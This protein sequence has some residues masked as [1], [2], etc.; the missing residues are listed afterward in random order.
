MGE[1]CPYCRQGKRAKKTYV[2]NVDVDGMVHK[3]EFGNSVL[4]QLIA[5]EPNP[6]MRQGAIIEVKRVGQ[7]LQTQY[8]VLSYRPPAVAKPNNTSQVCDVA[9]APTVE[10]DTEVWGEIRKTVETLGRIKDDLEGALE[11][12]KR[13]IRAQEGDNEGA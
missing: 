4:R 3:W 1:N 5:H 11:F 9:Q 10:V 7:G 6:S 12:L 2:Y 13:L 8:H